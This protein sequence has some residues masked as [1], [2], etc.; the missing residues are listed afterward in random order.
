MSRAVHRRSWDRTEIAFFVALVAAVT[1]V[2]VAAARAIADGWYP[3]G[4]DAFAG[5]RAQDVFSAHPPLLGTWSSASLWSHQWINHPGPAQFFVLAAPVAVFGVGTGVVL[6]TALTNGAAI[7]GA[8]LL[9]RRR[10]GPVFGAVAMAFVATLCW[11]L[12]SEL[13]FDPWS[14]NAP[15]FPFLVFLFGVWSVADGDIGVLWVPVVAGSFA[16]QTHLSYVLLVPGLLALALVAWGAGFWRA[17][18]RGGRS[19]RRTRRHGIRSLLISG[20][21]LLLCWVPPLYEQVTASPGNLTG[22]VRAARDTPPGTPGFTGAVRAV[23]EIVAVPPFWLPSS[24]A[25]PGFSRH[26]SRH[27]VGLLVALLTLLMAV[28]AGLA[29]MAWRRGDRMVCAGL[30]T[31]VVASGVAFLSA[32]R[33]TSPFGLVANYVEWLWPISMFVWLMI[34]LGAYRAARA[35][36]SA[37]IPRRLAVAAIRRRH[38]RRRGVATA[39]AAAAAVLFGALAIPR[40]N[41]GGGAPA[42]SVPVAKQVFAE[43]RPQLPRHGTVLV[44]MPPSNM[45]ALYGDAVA[46]IG[47]ALLAELR[48]HDIPFVVRGPNNDLSMVR[49]V[50]DRRRWD[51]HN[52]VVEV[53]IAATRSTSAVQGRRVAMHPGISRAEEAERLHLRASLIAQVRQS[54]GLRLSRA[55]RRLVRDHQLAPRLLRV[56]SESGTAPENVFQATTMLDLDGAVDADALDP[57][58]L[59]RYL[60]LTDAWA[61]HNVLVILS[62]PKY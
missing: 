10:G 14:Q 55:G 61:H 15:I 60:Q 57:G 19:W 47:P 13:L 9:A 7:V 48:S 20:G 50:G 3:T 29:V 6:G 30:G 43:L 45:A 18:G 8:G 44:N 59:H 27:P 31:A 42:W 24:W 16:V 58:E 39:G 32:A 52:A 38:L 53:T 46:S 22:L 2:L 35:A 5:L 23:G 62:P 56:V 54:G 12:G 26:G 40:A 37:T 33:S 21:V 1:P 11:T 49:Q 28:V 36:L 17:R 34:A 51:G 4:D 25:H 41:R